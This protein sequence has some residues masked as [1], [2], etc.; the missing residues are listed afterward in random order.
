MSPPPKGRGALK[1]F[2]EYVWPYS[3]LLAAA[4]AAGMLKFVL[5]STTA[6]ALKFL[7]DRLVPTMS[8]SDSG[9]QSR[10]D[11]VVRVIDALLIRLSGMLPKSWEDPWGRFNLLMLLLLGIYAL[12]AVSSFYRSY[13]AAVAGHRTMLDLRTDLYA[14]LTRLSHGFF[15]QRQSGAI[16]SRLMADIALAQNFVGTAMT[17]IWMD[18]VSCV[19]YVYVLFSMDAPLAWA[20]LGVFPFYVLSMRGFGSLTKQST[21]ELQEA[22]ETFSGD[23]QERIGGIHMVKSYTAERREVRAF[24]GGAR[25]LYDLTMRNAVFTSLSN[26]VVQWLTQMATVAIIWF[27]G[28]RLVTGKT[29]VGTVVAFILLLRELYFP[30]SRMSEL[31]AVLQNSLA[32]IERIFEVFDV[33]PDVKE[34]AKPR[35]LSSPQGAVTLEAVTFGYGATPV[36]HQVSLQVKPGEVVALVGPSGAGKSTLIQLVPRFYDPQAGRVLVDGVDVRE[37]K[38][39]PLRTLVGMVAQDTLLLSGTVRENILYGKPSATEAEVVSAAKAAHA[40]EFVAALPSG[41]DTP[42]GERGTRLSGG[43][44]QRI[45]LARAFL[46]DP[47]VLILD[48][49]TSAL[50]SESEALIQQSLTALMRGRTCIAIAHRL[51]TI[52]HADRIAVMEAGRIVEIG[53]HAELIKKGGLYARLYE[54]QFGPV[55]AA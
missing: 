38:L 7:T 49:A 6:L 17:N 25:R 54:S 30:V 55:R 31:N 19:F 32:A 35:A 10:S 34:P 16:V 43:Q 44:K 28:Y 13:W 21:H 47:K 3:G 22:M 14:H 9:A 1:R 39:R 29:T 41:Y 11:V 51:S 27:G 53:P 23:V 45:A 36:L 24:F 18:L 48:E 26:S 52:V 33:E 2:F 12:W 50:D 15:A 37:L 20:A 46:K 5:P 4:T 40:H 42:L 8:G